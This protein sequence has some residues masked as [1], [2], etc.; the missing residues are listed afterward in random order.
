MS[1]RDPTGYQSTTNYRFIV[2]GLA[3]F[4]SFSAG[5]SMFA[6][7][8]IVP[9]IMA[10]YGI[11]NSVAGFLTSIMFLV[12]VVLAIPAS[13]LVGRIG[14]KTLIALGALAGSIPLLSFMATDNF[15]L[16]LAIRAIYGFGFILLFPAI[17]PLFMQWFSPKELPFVN[18]VF[19]ISGS[20]GLAASTFLV[21]PLSETL[22][23][24]V[25]LSLFGS[26]SMLSTVTWLLFG[27]AQPVR[28]DSDP[29]SLIPRVW[30][31]ISSRNTLLVAAADAG[32]LALLTVSLG[33]LPTLY[34]EAHNMSLEKGGALMGLLSLAGFI[35]L[36]LASLLTTRISKR[37]PFLIFPGILTG[38][39]GLA[40]IMLTDSVALYI[41]I[42]VLG[43][44]CWFY[45]P[46]LITIPM[47]M[48]PNNPR[49]VSII[50]ATIMSLGGIASFVSPPIVGALADMTGSLAP[51]LT[52]FAVLAWSLAIAGVL[53]PE[54]GT[55]QT[56]RGAP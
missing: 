1:S 34:H 55:P 10:D 44:A 35:A 22:G 6:I 53:L 43:F 11:N 39:A 51:G 28:T 30:E 14:L 9:L 40:A 5:L 36:V 54:T 42:V 31:A 52:V 49:R 56:V 7:G 19:M 50:F 32:P 24:G 47:E 21:A 12:Q 20:L 41:G 23:W 26:V 15:V 48:Y 37:R 17:G 45:L 16:L 25:A 33:W 29:R 2:A 38:F 4:L 18:G 27:K 8:P 3:A 13:L 46:A